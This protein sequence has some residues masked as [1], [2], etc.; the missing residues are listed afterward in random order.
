MTF[1]ISITVCR[2]QRPI[3]HIG[4]FAHVH[5]ATEF[6]LQTWPGAALLTIKPVKVINLRQ[7]AL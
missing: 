1:S 5:A 3:V 2:G 6:A 4:E 7:E